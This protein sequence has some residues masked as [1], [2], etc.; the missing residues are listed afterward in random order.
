MQIRNMSKIQ[1]K[2]T[3]FPMLCIKSIGSTEILTATFKMSS[4]EKHHVILC[5]MVNRILK[6]ISNIET[7][8]A[9]NKH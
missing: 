4:R 1:A 9:K 6:K 8:L 5:H 7:K 3:T 2:Y